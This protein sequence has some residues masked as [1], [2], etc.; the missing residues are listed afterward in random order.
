MLR[1]VP[2]PSDHSWETVIEEASGK[3][4]LT[5]CCRLDCRGKET[6][7]GGPARAKSGVIDDFGG[8]AERTA[9]IE[10]GHA[11]GVGGNQGCDVKLPWF[12][13]FCKKDSSGK[14]S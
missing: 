6:I 12:S 11:V 9:H 2:L 5:G 7:V 8:Q 10:H 3:R 13:W 4:L 1:L 14:F